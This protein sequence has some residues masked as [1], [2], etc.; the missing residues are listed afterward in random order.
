M[1]LNRLSQN[2]GPVHKLCYTPEDGKRIWSSEL[3]ACVVAMFNRS[4]RPAVIWILAT[5]ISAAFA[6]PIVLD[7]T[8]VTDLN[9]LKQI[10]VAIQ[11]FESANGVFPSE[12]ISSAG[13]PLLSWRV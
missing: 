5:S 9:N 13:A 2:W 8:G 7:Q 10:A 4:R 12:F 1:S 11:S 6:S 3:W